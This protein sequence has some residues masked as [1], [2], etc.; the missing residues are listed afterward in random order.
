MYAK[1]KLSGQKSD[2]AQTVQSMLDE[3][4]LTKNVVT[5][6]SYSSNEKSLRSFSRTSVAS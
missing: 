4:K 1:R 5:D 6:A 3:I 2:I